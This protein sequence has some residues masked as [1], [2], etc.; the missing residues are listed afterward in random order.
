MTKDEHMDVEASFDNKYLFYRFASDEDHG[1]VARKPDGSAVKWADFISPLTSAKD[2]KLLLLPVVPERDPDLAGFAQ[3]NLEVCGVSPLDEHNTRFLDF[4]H[5][6]FPKC[7]SHLI[8]RRGCYSTY[9][10]I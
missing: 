1:K 7:T 2:Q 8:T 3:E 10:F 5:Q 6:V 9:G 4:L